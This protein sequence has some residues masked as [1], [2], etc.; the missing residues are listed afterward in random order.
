MAKVCRALKSGMIFPYSETFANHPG[1][2]VIDDQS[3]KAKSKPAAEKE[4]ASSPKKA[5]APSKPVTTVS[6]DP[7]DFD[8]GDLSDGDL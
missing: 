3:E 6:E 2:E 4:D 8:L 1:F 5:P 7:D